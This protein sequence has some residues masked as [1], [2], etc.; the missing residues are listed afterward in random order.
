[1]IQKYVCGFMFNEARTRCVLIEKLKPAVQAGRLN[2][3]G[4]KVE[5]K[6]ITNMEAMIREFEEET[7]VT[8]DV[9]L[10]DSF[11]T[12]YNSELQVVFYRAFNDVAFAAANTMEKEQ[13][14]RRNILPPPD[15]C[16]DNLQW[17]IPLALCEERLAS[18]VM[19][20][21]DFTV[22]MGRKDV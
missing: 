2:G 7:G 17:L 19:F 11:A 10:W 3:V 4:G 12:G 1:M 21:W 14:K 13:V 5:E 22:D 9:W 8:T 20:E 15:R 16:M 6:D 18:R